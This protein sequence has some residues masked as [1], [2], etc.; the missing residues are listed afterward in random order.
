[1]AR[2]TEGWVDATAY[3]QIQPDWGYSYGGAE[4]PVIGARVVRLT[5]TKPKTTMPDTVL[6][7][8]TVRVPKAA[9]YP[10]EPSAVVVVPESLI[11]HGVTVEAGAP[12]AE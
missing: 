4:S 2:S 10:L 12:D 9:F 6:V 3:L 8:V 7:K 1:M 5:Q 11:Q